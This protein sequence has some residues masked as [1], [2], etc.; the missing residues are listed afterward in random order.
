[1]EVHKTKKVNQKTANPLLLLGSPNGDRTRVSGVRGRYPRP[2]DDGT[3]K[4]LGDFIQRGFAV[5]AKLNPKGKTKPEALW[6]YIAKIMDLFKVY[7]YLNAGASCVIRP[8]QR[9]N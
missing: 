4:S 9:P 1:M 3:V 5:W 7:F 2:L 6:H 8:P